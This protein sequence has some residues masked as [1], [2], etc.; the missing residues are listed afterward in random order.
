VL[1]LFAPLSG[2]AQLL[3]KAV[4]FLLTTV[5]MMVL[6]R[7]VLATVL[8][9]AVAALPPC[10]D[11]RR[12]S[13]G[14]CDPVT[15]APTQGPTTWVPVTPAPPIDV[16][17]VC[18]SEDNPESPRYLKTL[19]GAF[20]PW[21]A[22]K[23]LKANGP[24]VTTVSKDLMGGQTLK[25]QNA[26][27]PLNVSDFN[28]VKED[29]EWKA[30]VLDTSLLKDILTIKLFNGW[31][32][33]QKS[34]YAISGQGLPWWCFKPVEKCLL[35]DISLY[36]SMD[37]MVGLRLDYGHCPISLA[38]AHLP[39]TKQAT[40]LV[41]L[42]RV[43]DHTRSSYS[44]DTIRMT[45]NV[46]GFFDALCYTKDS[47]LSASETSLDLNKAKEP[48]VAG[49]CFAASADM[50]DVSALNQFDSKPCFTG[51][52]V[53]SLLDVNNR[54]PVL[55]VMDADYEWLLSKLPVGRNQCN[56]KNAMYGAVKMDR[57][58]VEFEGMQDQV[59]K[60]TCGKVCSSNIIN[61]GTT[62]PGPA[63]PP[64]IC[65]DCEMYEAIYAI[66]ATFL[67]V[68]LSYYTYLS[69]SMSAISMWSSFELPGSP[70]EKFGELQAT[71]FPTHQQVNKDL[72]W[73][74]VLGLFF[75]SMAW[76][77]I[78]YYTINLL[79]TLWCYMICHPQ[80]IRLWP[81]QY[82]FDEAH[83]LSVNGTFAQ[84]Q[85]SHLTQEEA[86]RWILAWDGPRRMINI[87]W[88][89]GRLM[90]LIVATWF[91]TWFLLC[92]WRAEQKVAVKKTIIKTETITEEH[93][94]F[95]PMVAVGG[96]ATAGAG[97]MLTKTL[98]FFGGSYVPNAANP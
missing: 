15:P 50:E 8:V 39:V 19:P 70:H 32:D 75:I 88:C 76:S 89:P 5:T 81:F 7:I 55:P 54:F 25:V 58:C 68:M 9:V 4:E 45:P 79:D 77:F 93:G 26:G 38:D 10:D 14:P 97:G 91:A 66:I 20:K 61:T 47:T 84:Q 49:T 21:V 65:I 62:T 35:Q 63:I 40:I 67:V 37:D 83:Y 36:R 60:N 85:L 64:A 78:V 24:F 3:T 6:P 41:G 43:H 46:R 57:V 2:C 87:D 74:A 42:R 69:N 22:Y 95:S 31:C 53:Y 23:Y 11:A 28:C 71:N 12:L 34:Q 86:G 98:A 56:A 33:V 52:T 73:P 94:L 18:L 44:N 51:F 59:C 72:F 48:D 80:C 27:T 96:T 16:Q 30:R 13:G 90:G 1:G 17:P 82:A 92:W 29:N